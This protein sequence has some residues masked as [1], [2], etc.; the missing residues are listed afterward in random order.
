MNAKTIPFSVFF[1]A[2]VISQL[3]GLSIISSQKAELE[4]REMI[5]NKYLERHCR[6]SAPKSI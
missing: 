6:Q 5:N 2:W 3:K 1:K 4:I